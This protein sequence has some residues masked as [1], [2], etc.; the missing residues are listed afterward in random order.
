MTAS[1]RSGSK[2]KRAGI[3]HHECLEA[4]ALRRRIEAAAEALIALLDQLDAPAED[5]EP[6]ADWEPWLAAPEDHPC[7]LNWCRGCDDDREH[8]DRLVPQ[9]RRP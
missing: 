3:L 7:Q 5:L 4:L 1:T 9:V 6:D 2:T 8:E